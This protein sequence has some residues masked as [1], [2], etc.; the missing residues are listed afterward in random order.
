MAWLHAV[1]SLIK[2]GAG[3]SVAKVPL[4]QTHGHAARTARAAST[5]DVVR[6][7]FFID[8]Q[9]GWLVCEVNAYQLKTLEEPRLPHENHRR[10][11]TC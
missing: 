8:D 3:S 11:R 2:T 5:D 6:D 7:I 10:W 1:F 4:L 9:N